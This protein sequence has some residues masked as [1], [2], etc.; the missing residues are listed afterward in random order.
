ML[1]LYFSRAIDDDICITVKNTGS[2]FE[3]NIIEKIKERHIVPQGFGIG[4]RNIHDRLQLA[5]GH[6]YG[7]TVS[8]EE[9]MAVVRVK[10][11]KIISD[12]K[13]A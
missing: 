1:Y 3:D 13:E 8:N 6:K 11:P 2:E 7:L 9:N 10:L 4:L 5:Y 12:T